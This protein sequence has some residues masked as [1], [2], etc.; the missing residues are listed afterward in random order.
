MY[1]NKIDILNFRQLTRYVISKVYQF[2][3]ELT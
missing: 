1:S 3:L 2:K